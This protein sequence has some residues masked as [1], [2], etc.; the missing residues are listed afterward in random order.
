VVSCSLVE[1]FLRNVGTSLPNYKK[2]HLRRSYCVYHL[3]DNFKS[4]IHKVYIQWLR[5]SL[6]CA[7]H[8]YQCRIRIKHTAIAWREVWLWYQDVTRMKMFQVLC[9]G[10]CHRRILLGVSRTSY[11]RGTQFDYRRRPM[12]TNKIVLILSLLKFQ[13]NIINTGLKQ[14]INA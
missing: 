3:N 11:L 10:I 14:I 12:N 13:A 5:F 9:S 1:R 2:S 4:D 8:S 6:G 7:K